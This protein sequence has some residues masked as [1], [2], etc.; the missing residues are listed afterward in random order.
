MSTKYI[1]AITHSITKLY[2]TIDNKVAQLLLVQA[3]TLSKNPGLPTCILLWEV[4][5]EK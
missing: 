1:N 2:G 3:K 4:D 5:K